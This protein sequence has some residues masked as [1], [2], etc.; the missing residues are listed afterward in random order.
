MSLP[1]DRLD[2]LSTL[3]LPGFIVEWHCS[4]AKEILRSQ[5]E[6]YRRPDTGRLQPRRHSWHNSF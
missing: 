4:L 6:V 3:Q 1:G 2:K 5:G